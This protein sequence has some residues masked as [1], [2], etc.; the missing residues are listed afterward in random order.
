M[1]WR[2]INSEGTT[3]RVD[4]LHLREKKG[5][6]NV[7]SGFW[8]EYC[9]LLRWGRPAETSGFEHKREEEGWQ[10]GVNSYNLVM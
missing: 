2:K 8:L 4:G 10:R 3:E 1:D 9:H 6:Q 5:I 7:I